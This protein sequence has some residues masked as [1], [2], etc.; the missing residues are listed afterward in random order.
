MKTKFSGILTLLLAFIVQVSFAQEKTI[1]GTVSDESGMPLPGVNIIVKGTTNGTQTD[2]DGNYT[3]NASAGDVLTFTYVGLKTVEQTV[4]SSNTINVTMQ[5]D[6]ALLDEVVVTALGIKREKKSLGYAQ[7]SVGGEELVKAKETDI[8]DALAGKVAGVQIVGNNSST[9]GNSSIRLRGQT[10]LLYVVDGVRVYAISDINPEN[11]ADIS[12]LKSGAATALYGPDGRSGAIVITTKTAESGVAQFQIDQA[13]TINQ[14][15][16][17]PEY[18]NEYGGGYSQTFN[19]FTYNPATDPAEWAAFD[20]QPYP[21]FWADESWGPRLDGTLVRH[22]DSWVPGTPEFGE[23][24]PWSPSKNDINTFYEDAYTN[25]TTLSFSKGGEDYNIRTSLTY[26]EANGIIPNSSNKSTRFALNATY[27]ITEKF[28]FFANINVEDR[29]MLNNPDQGYAN[30]GSNFNQWWQRQLD[31]K[32][33][34]RYERNGQVVSWNIRGPRDARP[35]YWDM[36]Y[37]HSY[38]ND[39]NYRK[40]TYFGKVGGTYTFNDNFNITAEI[41]KTFNSYNTDDRGTTKSLL[42]PAFFS[43]SHSRNERIDYFAMA[44]YSDVALNGDIDYNVNLGVEKIHRDFRSLNANTVG[45]LTIPD[46]YNLAGSLDPVAASGGKRLQKN[47]GIFAKGSVSYKKFLYLD[48]SYR[49]DWSSTAN[50]EDNRVETLGAS[51]SFLAHEVLPKNDVVTFAKLRV[52]YSEAPYFPGPYLTQNVYT[53]G[54]LYQGNGRLGINSRQENPDLKGGVRSEFEVGTEFRLFNGKIG[55][56]LSYWDRTDD[57]LPINIPLDGATGYSNTNINSGKQTSSGFEVALLGDVVRNDN[58]TWELGVNFATLNR[59]VDALYPGIDSR[60]LSTYTSNMRLQER[61]GEEWGTLIG[62]GF[63]YGANGEIMYR[64][65]SGGRYFY[66]RQTNKNLGNV[67]PDFTGGLTSN[68]TYKN[69]DLSLGFDFQKGGKYYSRTERYMD[70][71]GLSAKTAGL[72]D[73]G[74]PKRDPVA[75]GGG[76]HIVGVLETGTDANGQPTSDGT[77]V[78]A[79]VEAQDLYNLGNLGNIY[80]NNLHDASYIK[81]RS[82]KLNYNFEKDFVSKFS[83]TAAS[84]GFFANNVWLIDSEL[85]WVDPS[86]LERRGGINWA[87]AGTLPQ[88]RS[89]G[90]NLRLTF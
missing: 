76:V 56:D 82:V 58:F 38:E 39:N 61:V 52:G 10:D 48:G 18:Q 21:D 69:W 64:A 54:S 30:L 47:D 6:A 62:R 14:V 5:E 13:F 74:N 28:E 9:F 59:Y 72:N 65:A 34:K 32:R 7:Q 88:T 24:R 16:N 57:Q 41:R 2:F 51:A 81:L 87:E 78:D 86:E 40:N 53:V 85:N 25:N 22:W 50:P 35:L 49:L 36:P 63:A 45:D 37:F 17:L 67:L 43:E 75:S 70:H 26:V 60:D 27:N 15:T 79:Y 33:L 4:G 12:V 29:D 46:F 19:T 71:S 73:K 83:L 66:S 23:L 77:V 90:V 68:M 42:D 89:M 55:L 20:G 84:I 8:A 80:E 31:F 44:T 11:V 1:S 3:I